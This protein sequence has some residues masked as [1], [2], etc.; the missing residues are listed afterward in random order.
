MSYNHPNL[1]K[2][3]PKNGINQYKLDT[4]RK[5]IINFQQY[6]KAMRLNETETIMTQELL[7]ALILGIARNNTMNLEQREKFTKR[8]MNQVSEEIRK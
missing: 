7:M 1:N 2:D 8:L 3:S 5:N 6:V 4:I